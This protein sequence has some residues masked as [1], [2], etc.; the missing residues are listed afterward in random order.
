MKKQNKTKNKNIVW[1]KEGGYPL[2][3]F[4]KQNLYRNGPEMIDVINHILEY[5]S[6]VLM[7]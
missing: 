4:W 5:Q 1:D 3:K 2:G 7:V 6:R